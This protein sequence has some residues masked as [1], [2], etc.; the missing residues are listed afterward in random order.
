MSRLFSARG[1]RP[2]TSRS[3]NCLRLRSSRRAVSFGERGVLE[4]KRD[5]RPVE[6][7][8][9][10]PR[11]LA[12]RDGQA[13]SVRPWKAPSN[14]TMKPPS[15]SAERH[16]AIHQHGLDRILDRLG[17]GVDDEVARRAG[18]GDAVQFGLEPQ[19]QHR[20]IFGV[21]VA[22][23]DERQRIEHGRDDGRIVLAERVG[24]NQGAHVEKTIR[25]AGRRRDR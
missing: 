4:R 12:M 13:P 24:R 18:G 6:R 8:E 19:R 20:L 5:V 11:L 10:E 23:G 3:H 16:D 22:R 14:E 21:G 9:A 1:S 2:E 7:R 17:A 15:P 25:L